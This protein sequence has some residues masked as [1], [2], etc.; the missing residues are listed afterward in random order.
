MPAARSTPR[1]STTGGDGAGPSRLDA[2]R[3]AHRRPR[4][5]AGRIRACSVPS[6]ETARRCGCCRLSPGRSSASMPARCCRPD[7]RSS[8]RQGE[9]S[10][11]RSVPGTSG[12][13]RPTRAR[14]CA[15]T[16][17]PA[18]SLHCTWAGSRSGSPSPAATS[19][20]P[21][22][23]EAPSRAST[24]ERFGRSVNPSRSAP[25]QARL[26]LPAA[27][28]SSA[29]QGSARSP[30]STCDR[31][32]RPGLRSA[33]RSLRDAS[34]FALTPAGTSVW[35]SSFASSTLTRISSTAGGAP[36]P[37]AT[38]SKALLQIP[39]QG[40]FPRGARVTATIR[41]PPWPPG[42]GGLAIG[43]G[44][45]WSLQPQHRQAAANRSRDELGREADTGR[46]VRRHRRRGWV[47][48]ADEPASE[49]G[50]SD[51]PEDLSGERDDP[52]RKEPIGDRRD[53]AGRV[54]RQ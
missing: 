26:P 10:G 50:R 24:R 45:V 33:S 36:V 51:G 40:P 27:T 11:W 48:L 23:S 41:V 9:A 25:R 14:C 34:A 29:A 20:S 7:P 18:G 32:R 31:G 38:V 4:S 22:A 37:A 1:S 47:D 43:E 53:S 12:S 52:R 2:R 5:S 44:A 13:L 49:H 35:A 15:S 3:L 28:S 19:G 16:R 6:R 46:C 39:G 42:M 21:T 8:C 54:G 30:G 17:P